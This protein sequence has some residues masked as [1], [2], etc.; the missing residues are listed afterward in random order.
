M[1]AVGVFG[2]NRKEQDTQPGVGHA[3]GQNSFPFDSSKKTRCRESTG[4]FCRVGV[5]ISNFPFWSRIPCGGCF[6]I[7]QRCGI[8]LFLE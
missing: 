6:R 7:E 8:A 3:T 1:E 5:I 4:K 2:V